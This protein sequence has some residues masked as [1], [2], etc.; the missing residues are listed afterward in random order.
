MSVSIA[1]NLLIAEKLI[2]IE[3]L[4]LVFEDENDTVFYVLGKKSTLPDLRMLMT[5]QAFLERMLSKISRHTFYWQ[6]KCITAFTDVIDVITCT[7]PPS[8]TIV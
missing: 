7:D 4:V 5:E 2:C 8:L 6:G 1:N 3:V